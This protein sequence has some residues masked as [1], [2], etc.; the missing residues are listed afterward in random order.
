[1]AM[2]T[3]EIRESI[4]T[5]CEK[6]NEMRAIYVHPDQIMDWP[7]NETFNLMILIEELKKRVRDDVVHFSFKKKDGTVRQAYG[8]RL[9][10]IIVRHEGTV[11]PGDKTKRQGAVGS[12]FPYYD[13]ERGAWRCFKTESLMD[14]DRGYSI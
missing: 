13:I 3:Q 8:T 10:E 6:D 11:L 1:M 4:Q 9:T 5:L 14:I 7:I 12:T 2:T